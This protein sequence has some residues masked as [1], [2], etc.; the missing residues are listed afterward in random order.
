MADAQSVKKSRELANRFLSA[1][2]K[3]GVEVRSSVLTRASSNARILKKGVVR[4]GILLHV[5]GL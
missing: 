3:A 5:S 1:L 2:Q 4:V